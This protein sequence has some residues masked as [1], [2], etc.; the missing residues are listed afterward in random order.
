MAA[1]G[2]AGVAPHNLWAEHAR[3]GVAVSV[4]IHPYMFEFVGAFIHIGG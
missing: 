4:Y 2:F 3:I 1:W